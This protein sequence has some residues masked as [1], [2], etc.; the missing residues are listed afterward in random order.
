[1]I[2]PTKTAPSHPFRSVRLRPTSECL[3][4][5][6]H[7]IVVVD[8]LLMISHI[9]NFLSQYLLHPG[10]PI[11]P[12]EQAEIHPRPRPT[13]PRCGERPLL[14]RSPNQISP[15]ASPPLVVCGWKKPQEASRSPESWRHLVQLAV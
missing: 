2:T 10:T 4:L 11:H 7:N 13:P 9:I 1:M 3:E 6:E 12:P 14:F 5:V 15:R 8:R